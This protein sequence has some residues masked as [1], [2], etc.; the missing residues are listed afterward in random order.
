MKTT[1]R[2]GSASRGA[3]IDEGRTAMREEGGRQKTEAGKRVWG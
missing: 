3:H 2:K 1:G